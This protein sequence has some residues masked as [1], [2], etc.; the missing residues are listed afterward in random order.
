MKYFVTGATGF[1]GGRVVRL[2]RAEGHEVSAVVRNPTA[3]DELVATGTTLYPGD[4]IGKETMRVAMAGVDGVF[5]LAGW[6]KV[7]AR[8][9]EEAQRVNVDGTRNVLELVREL[10]IPRCV[11]TSTLAVFSDT[12]GRLVDETYCFA[13]RHLSEYDRT[14]AAAH[15]VARAMIGDGVPVVIV[16]PGM[17]YGPGDT[18]M[19]RTML[20]QYLNRRLPAVPKRTAY[21]WAHV[22]D[23]ARA[24]VLAMERGRIGESYIIAGPSSTLEAVLR[25]AE[26]L[27]GIPAPPIVPPEILAGLSHVMRFIERIVSVPESYASETLRV[28]AGATYLGSSAK[29]ARELGFTA[30]PLEV[31]LQETLRHEMRLLGLEAKPSGRV[32]AREAKI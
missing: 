2:L 28:M 8:Q 12:H 24:H 13:G 18:S 7:G 19:V 16:Q 30:R 17:N 21:C 4:V 20:L 31:G 3:A 25:L 11:Y 6:Y 23:T 1:I 29:A 26:E 22:D 27:T 14:K 32:A 5:H 9:R 10:N 15:D